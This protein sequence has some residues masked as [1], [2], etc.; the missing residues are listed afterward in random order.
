MKILVILRDEESGLGMGVRELHRAL[1]EELSMSTLY[2]HLEMLER[3]EF[4]HYN[5]KRSIKLIKL[6]EKGK[7]VADSVAEIFYLVKD[8]FSKVDYEED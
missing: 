7:K 1:G 4:I 3:N 2:R 5:Q 6:T 8:D